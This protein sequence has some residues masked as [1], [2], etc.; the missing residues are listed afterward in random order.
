[1]N[2]FHTLTHE[3]L[4]KGLPTI[5]SPG[6]PLRVD[7]LDRLGLL[8]RQMVD[9][10]RE[11]LLFGCEVGFPRNVVCPPGNC[12]FLHFLL[13]APGYSLRPYGCHDGHGTKLADRSGA[14]DRAGRSR[15][16]VSRV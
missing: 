9:R 12:L 11:S 5:A 7:I 1:M 14:P 8:F 10:H 4:Y 16:A 2:C 6:N 13:A 15:R 3:R